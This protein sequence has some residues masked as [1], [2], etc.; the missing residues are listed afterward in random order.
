M[1]EKYCEIMGYGQLLDRLIETQILI[2][3]NLELF[4]NLMMEKDGPSIIVLNFQ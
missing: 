2:T 1:N 4:Q 3:E